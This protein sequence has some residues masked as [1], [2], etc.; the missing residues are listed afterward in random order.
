MKL[1]WPDFE[2]EC[3]ADGRLIFDWH[4]FCR[5]GFNVRRCA[6]IRLVPQ[7]PDGAHQWIFQLRAQERPTPGLLVIRVDVP[8]DRVNEADEYTEVLRRHYGVPERQDDAGEDTPL[9]RTPVDSQQWIVAPAGA[10]SEELFQ[11]V[12]AR[13]ADDPG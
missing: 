5:I 3:T 7:G 13:V 1:D 11:D 8:Q 6:S 2:L 10:A 4:G 9:E 12:M